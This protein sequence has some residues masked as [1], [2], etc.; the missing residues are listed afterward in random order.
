MNDDL[1]WSHCSDLLQSETTQSYVNQH[2]QY[3]QEQRKKKLLNT[4]FG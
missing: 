4:A 3:L 1:E 2:Q